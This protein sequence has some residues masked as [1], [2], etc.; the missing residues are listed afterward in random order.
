[1]SQRT[2]AR[3]P[4]RAAVR[5]FSTRGL[6]RW[7]DR[8]PELP[9]LVLS[10]G[11]WELAARLLDFAFL[12]RFSAVFERSIE[13]MGSPGFIG[14]LGASGM[15]F[16]LG[17]LLAV[18]SGVAV[19]VLIGRFQLLSIAIEPY[20]NA[21]L[22]TPTLIFAPALFMIFGL[23]R[24]TLVVVVF[25]Y[26]FPIVAL[27]TMSG[28]QRVDPS[29]LE[30]ARVFGLGERK[31]I[32]RIVIPSG[33]PLLMAGVRLGVSRG[34]K[35]TINGE[36]LIALVGLGGLVRALGGAFDA[37]G[38]LAVLLLV[39]SFSLLVGYLVRRIDRRILWWAHEK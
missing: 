21:L 8:H 27:N 29:F 7:I 33:L 37:E 22:V 14:D 28:V 2:T 10:A 5:S 25:L 26:I 35:G 17:Y 1:M 4:S 24:S 23:G 3:T 13:L 9:A 31:I 30:M 36:M 38:V 34:V 19:G 6:P 39:T 15:N 20:V 12:P 16:L 32:T 11:A 18:S